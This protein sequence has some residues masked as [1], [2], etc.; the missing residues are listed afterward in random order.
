[1]LTGAGFLP[2]TVVLME[3]SSSASIMVSASISMEF[4][5]DTFLSDVPGFCTNENGNFPRVVCLEFI[6]GECRCVL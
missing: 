6:P 4:P 2:S 5:H 1:M 3:S